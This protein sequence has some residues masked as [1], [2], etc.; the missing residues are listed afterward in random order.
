MLLL[1]IRPDACAFRPNFLPGVGVGAAVGGAAG[2]LA[3]RLKQAQR[4]FPWCLATASLPIQSSVGMVPGDLQFLQ[5]LLPP[6]PRSWSAPP[7]RTRTARPSTGARPGAPAAHEMLAP[8]SAAAPAGR[9]PASPA[10]PQT[11]PAPRLPI[12]ARKSQA[13]GLA[14]KRWWSQGGSNSR[15]RHCERRALPAEL[16]PRGRG[17]Y[18]PV[19]VLANLPGRVAVIVQPRAACPGAV[20]RCG[21]GARPSGGRG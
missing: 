3:H 17:F 14:S 1:P 19:P 16:W 20:P 7:T 9:R 12:R 18:W 21:P 6:A 5:V 13:T 2:Q 10:P 4:D 15:P 11:Q 8:A